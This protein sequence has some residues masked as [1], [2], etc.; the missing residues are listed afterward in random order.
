MFLSMNNVHF[1][2]FQLHTHNANAILPN[3][4]LF[5]GFGMT[6]PTMPP[7]QHGAQYSLSQSC[8]VLQTGEELPAQLDLNKHLNKC[9][10]D[11]LESFSFNRDACQTLLI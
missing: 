7:V 6:L 11:P 4:R 3:I 2:G 10:F 5:P 9:F 1:L 8:L